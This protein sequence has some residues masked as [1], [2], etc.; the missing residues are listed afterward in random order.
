MNHFGSHLSRFLQAQSISIRQF[1]TAF[2]QH[3]SH[4]SVVIK[5]TEQLSKA[6]LKKIV[7]MM[8]DDPKR[9]GITSSSIARACARSFIV[10]WMRDQV[11]EGWEGE[12]RITADEWTGVTELDISIDPRADAIAFFDDLSR[13]NPVVADWLIGSKAVMQQPQMVDTRLSQAA[14][15]EAAKRKKA[16]ELEAA[17]KG[18]KSAGKQEKT[19]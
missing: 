9:V 19:G 12:I 13:Q 2:E 7:D 17:G 3:A 16:A 18:G 11:P 15:F 6:N 5:G 14:Q 10:H 4:I 8:L 1:S